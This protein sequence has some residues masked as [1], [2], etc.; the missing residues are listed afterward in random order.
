LPCQFPVSVPGRVTSSSSERLAPGEAASLQ[1]RTHDD[2]AARRARHR[3]ADQQEV[4]RGVDF[5]DL[6]LLDRAADVAHVAGHALA[7]EHASRGLALAD[8]AGGAVE[9]RRA[10]RSR[11]A[12]EVVP[13]H[14]AGKA[15]A[16]GRA[17]DVD[18]LALGEQVDLELG[19]RGEIGA[20]AVGEAELD[21]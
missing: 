10:V 12:R 8:R 2:F 6:Q 4:A 13:L 16:D 11:A 21:Q 1:R 20:F 5:D 3:A 9:H 18:D 17:R 15:L 19:A 7:L 14:R